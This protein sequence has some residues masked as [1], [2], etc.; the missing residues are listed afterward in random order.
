VDKLFGIP[1]DQLLTILLAVF[2]GV[3]ALLAFSALRNRVAFKMASRNI[4]RRRAQTALIVLGLMLATL[5]FSASFTTGDTLTNSF[6]TMSTK[7]L[8]QVD[9]QVKSDAPSPSAMQMGPVPGSRDAYFDADLTNKVRKRLADD[10]S[11]SGVASLAAES[12]SVVSPNDYHAALRH[13]HPPNTF[14]HH[15]LRA[16][17]PPRS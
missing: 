4:P 13:V 12:A 9:V 7:S 6:R 5:L 3:A 10:P 17:L 16:P 15:G 1:V 8:G 14:L 2:G 11:V